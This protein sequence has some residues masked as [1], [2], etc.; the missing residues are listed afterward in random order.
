MSAAAGR[1]RRP[2]DRSGLLVVVD[3]GNTNTIFGVYQGDA[4]VESFRLSTN[5]ERTADEYGSLLLPLFTRWGIDPMAAEAVVI[6]SVVPPLHLTLDH[7]ARR[8]FGKRPLF[9]E[10]G[11]R[12]GMPIRYDNPAE[13][14]A[15]R[16][17]NAVAARE[18]Y[19]APV[20]VVDFGTATTFDLVN[21]AG[22]YVGGIIAPG[23]MI[24]A[25]ALWAHASRLY[26]VDVRKPAELVGK[27]TVGAMQAGIYYGYIGL[28][29]GILERLL[30][31][32][33]GVRNIIAT[34]G[35]APLIASGSKH[36]REVDLDLTLAGLKLIYERNRS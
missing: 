3:V 9:I 26:R 27:N 18:R 35:Q 17:V 36:I 32:I 22:E 29:D 19:G 16:I 1:R 24:S 33:P 30:A 4:M 25:E 34:G 2:E 15:D 28:V 7:L 11:V 8:Y 5:H 14:G 12:T 13:V 6:S 31:E 20:I 10:P 21:A 23:I